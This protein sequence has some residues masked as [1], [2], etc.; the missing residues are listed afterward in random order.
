MRK[1][2]LFGLAVVAVAV[3]FA[4]LVDDSDPTTATTTRAPATTGAPT[5]A[6]PATEVEFDVE[7]AT[8]DVSCVF[9]LEGDPVPF[10]NSGWGGEIY[11]DDPL[12]DWPGLPG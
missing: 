1:P 3:L 9:T 6:A 5:T 11:D 10:T 12:D 4:L 8:F 7:N 2:L